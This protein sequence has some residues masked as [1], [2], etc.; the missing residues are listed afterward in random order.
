MHE[1]Y[2]TEE[3]ELLRWLRDK[4][5]TEGIEVEFKRAFSGRSE[6]LAKDIISLANTRGGKICFGIDDLSELKDVIGV[7]NPGALRETIQNVIND[8]CRPGLDPL[9]V[10]EEV[11]C[12]DRTVLILHVEES[13]NKPHYYEKNNYPR[14]FVRADNTSR[15]ANI[16]QIQRL[17]EERGRISYDNKPQ[18]GVS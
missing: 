10:S 5:T 16:D 3:A 12:S 1:T 7:E 14:I 4:R 15:P 9:P 17:F 2:E 11:P 13:N 8:K 18:Q 6:E